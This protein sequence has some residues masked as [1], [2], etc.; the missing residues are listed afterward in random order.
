YRRPAP[1]GILLH[2]PLS[3]RITP[4]DQADNT[5]QEGKQSFSFG[6]KE[7]F[8]GEL[9]PEPFQ[10]S[11]QLADAD[12]AN[13]QGGEQERAAAGVEV[14]LGPDDDAGAFGGSRHVEDL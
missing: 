2:V 7:P 3:R 9:A 1:L 5:G 8:R 11:Q 12:G 14:G 6:G 4:A 13:F 10:A